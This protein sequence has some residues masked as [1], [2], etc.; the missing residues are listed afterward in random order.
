MFYKRSLHPVIGILFV[1][2]SQILGYG[3]AGMMRK[4]LVWPA[5]MIWPA[6]L[7]NCA[8][9]RTLHNDQDNDSKEEANKE[10]R[11]KMTRLRFFFSVLLDLYDQA[12]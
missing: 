3:L 6:N 10:S 1:I 12:R 7:V 9:F 2:T 4:F 8:L 11:W 5:S